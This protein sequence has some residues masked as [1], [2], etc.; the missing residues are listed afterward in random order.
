MPEVTVRQLEGEEIKE[1]IHWLVMY[2]FAPSPPLPDKEKWWERMTKRL[3]STYLA[4]F[5]DD[6]PMACTV[7]TAMPQNVRGNVYSSGGVWWV[8]AHPSGRRK[9]YTRKLMAEQFLTMRREG[10]PLTCLYPFRESFYERLG[11]V[12]FPQEQVI[13][14]NPAN[15]GGLVKRDLPGD[16]TLMPIEEGR[17]LY[18]NYLRK[19]QPTVHG[20]AINPE[21]IA[22]LANLWLVVAQAGEEII[23][24]MIYK[25]TGEMVNFTM[26]VNRFYYDNSL[27]KYL[28][29]E[30][31]SR[32][33]D[34]AG[35]I[36]IKLSKA[37]MAETWL[38]DLDVDVKSSSFVSNRRITPMG[39][40]LDIAALD[41][42]HT[43]P[44][45]FSANISD[46]FCTWNNGGYL[47]ETIGG[48]LQI[49]AADDAECDLTIQA[50][51]GLIYGTHNPD[52]FAFR[53]WGTPS[54]EL[55]ARMRQV[56]PPMIPYLHEEF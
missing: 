11:Y 35:S 14:F 52:D 39:R 1:V 8:A 24:L 15:L 20:M 46:P 7:H 29:L 43:G 56:F 13:T 16:V 31:L 44:G 6:K 5:E 3:G 42:M 51:S 47:F 34:Q 19:H 30:W 40:V 49:S 22:Q 36:E 48:R 53:G 50:L 17:D 4:L 10:N 23:G 9:G 26:T 2:A 32:H 12:T 21:R 33:I 37:E 25:L 41:G 28:L 27:G 38:A 54:T 18:L 45:Q 55:Q